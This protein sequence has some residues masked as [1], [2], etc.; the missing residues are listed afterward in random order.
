M[1]PQ[2]IVDKV[3]AVYKPN[4]RYLKS[5]KVD[6]PVARGRFKIGETEYFME[7]M[8]HLTDVEAQLCL[9]QLSYVFFGQEVVNRRW[10]DLENLSFEQ[11]LEL[12]NEGMFVVESHKTFHRETDSREP[13]NGEIKL[14][15]VRRH[16][17]IYVAKIE[18]DLNEGAST[19]K[20]SLILK[21]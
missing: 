13:F 19:G 16:K 20:L 11:F 5:V 15:K 4:Y 6:F 17:N 21:T 3:L 7:S 14:M 10:K 8:R 9:N 12:R 1:L 2:E 18:Y